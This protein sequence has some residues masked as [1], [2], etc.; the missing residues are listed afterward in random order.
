MKKKVTVS[1]HCWNSMSIA[2]SAMV[3]V[4]MSFTN[5]EMAEFFPEYNPYSL[6]FSNQN[7]EIKDGFV[8]I[9]DNEG[10]GINIDTRLLMED[11]SSYKET[12]F[13]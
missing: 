3:H 7:Y 11:T 9:E 4:C 10:L 1:P 2:A 13:A 8:K 12:E 6:K 5:T